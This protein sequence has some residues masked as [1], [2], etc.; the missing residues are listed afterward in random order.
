MLTRREILALQSM[1]AAGAFVGRPLELS[2]LFGST[3]AAQEPDWDAGELF[4]LLPTANHDRVL[5]KCS[6]Q[7]PLPRPPELHV[8]GRRIPGQRTDTPGRFWAFDVDSL[9]PSTAYSFELRSGRGGALA[10]PWTLSTFPAPDSEIDHVRIGFYHC[11]GGHEIS[12]VAHGRRTSIAVRRALLSKLASLQPTA[13]VANGDHVYW[14]LYSPRFASLYAESEEGLAYVG[15]FDRSQ[16]IF[17]TSNEDFVLKGGVEQIAPIYRTT[18]RSTPVFFLQDDHDYFDNDDATDEVVT[19]PPDHA[20]L[21]L[22]RSVQKLAYPE[23]LPDPFRPRGLPGSRED[24][25]RPEISSNFGTL[26]YGKLLEVLLYDNRRSATTLGPSAVQFDPTVESWLK[27]RMADREVAHVVNAPGQPPGW[28]RGNWYEYYPD[29]LRDGQAVV[30]EPKPYW[31]SGWLAQ[32]DRIMESIYRMPERIPLV[33]SGDIHKSAHA[34]ILGVGDIDMADNPVVTILP[35]TPGTSGSSLLTV[36]RPANHLDLSD[37]WG[38]IGEN[39]F[40]VADFYRNRVE[41]SFYT[42]DSRTQSID[43]IADLDPA[44]VTTLEPVA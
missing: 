37:E 10:E 31:P 7:A 30:S 23:F 29:L 19:F 13:I 15:R 11:A 6:F 2:S 44:Y 41:C 8:D 39:G 3:A 43:S 24:E 26:R 38:P 22:A 40:M 4:H 9:R 28:T 32:H 5:L 12:A 20:M 17:G 36:D 33:I 34:R 35:G 42:W 18:F 25:G 21:A 16:P 14:D 27:A 1:L